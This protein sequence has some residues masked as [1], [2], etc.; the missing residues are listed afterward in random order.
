LLANQP[1][2]GGDRV[3][4]VTNAGGLGI[5][6][7]DTCEANGLSV[8][9][10]AAETVTALRSFLPEEAAVSNPVDMIASASPDDYGRAIDTVAGDPGIDALIAIYIPPAEEDAPAVARA[11]AE[12]IEAIAGRIPVLTCFMSASGLPDALDAPGDRVPSFA[13]PEQAAIALAHATQLGLWRARPEG[14]TVSIDVREDEVAAVIAEALTREEGWLT[15]H[16]VGTLLASYGVPTPRQEAARTPEEAATVAASFPGSVAL[17]AIGP[18]H[19]TDLGA[20]SLDLD[21]ARVQAE[22]EAISDRVLR[23]GEPL[24][25]F[26]VQEMIPPGVEMLVGAVAD[27][28]FG[29]VIAVSAGGATVEL[30]RDVAVRVAPLTDLDADEMIRS[31]VTFPLLDGFRGAPKADVDALRDIV[32]RIGAMATAHEAVAE[33]DCNPVIVHPEGAV[34]VDA[35]ISVRP[36]RPVAPFAAPAGD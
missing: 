9:E 36:P 26:L 11:M 24:E 14:K 35:R 20:V 4:I 31:L 30:T 5:M 34:V 21:A 22:A 13:Y 23:A 6:C 29:P 33:L 18:L 16:D 12:A 15:P 2:P 27:P 8:P 32:L 10:L 7:A 3:A 19:K 17:K 25:G 1:V 28:V